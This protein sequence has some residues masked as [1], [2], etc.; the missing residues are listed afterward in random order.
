[1]KERPFGVALIA[2]L[3]GI[4]A[5]LNVLAALAFMG[6]S[7]VGFFATVNGPA[8][9]LMLMAIVVLAIGVIELIVAVSMWHMER[10][11]WM[12]TVIISW[13]SILFDFIGGIAGTTTWGMSFLSMVIPVIVLI[14]FYQPGVQKAFGR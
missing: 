14:Y 2:I 7:A 5:V 1:M 12:L 8:A 9:V 6:V 10:W 3:I 11:T 4:E 13:I